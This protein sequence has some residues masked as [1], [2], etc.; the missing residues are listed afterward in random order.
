MCLVDSQVLRFL[1]FSFL[2]FLFLFTAQLEGYTISPQF[3]RY[4]TRSRCLMVRRMDGV[5][6]TGWVRVWSQLRRL[7]SIDPYR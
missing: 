5:K 1:F 7:G 2:S 6:K 4:S 3:L